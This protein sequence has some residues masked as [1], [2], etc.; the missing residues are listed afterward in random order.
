MNEIQTSDI[1]LED[2]MEL[3]AAEG[4][5]SADESLHTFYK[6]FIELGHIEN[7]GDAYKRIIRLM[8]QELCIKCI[9]II[10]NTIQSM[11]KN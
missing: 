2:Y 6:K 4:S 10:Q 3:L 7:L 1:P 5:L 9:L 8:Q 11:L